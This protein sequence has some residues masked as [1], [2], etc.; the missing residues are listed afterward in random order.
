MPS[1]VSGPHLLEFFTSRSPARVKVFSLFGSILFMLLLS[2]G[3]S[4]NLRVLDRAGLCDLSGLF[5]APRAHASESP[6]FGL[7]GFRGVGVGSR[8]GLQRSLCP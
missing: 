4:I 1:G 7:L 3:T 6:G 2:P 8:S 5:E